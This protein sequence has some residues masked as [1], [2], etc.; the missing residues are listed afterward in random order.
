MSD[1]EL[2]S[3]GQDPGAPGTFD[4]SGADSGELVIITGGIADEDPDEGIEAVSDVATVD[5]PEEEQAAEFTL[6]ELVAE[7]AG[8]SALAAVVADEEVAPVAIPEHID[9]LAAAMSEA[10]AEAAPVEEEMWTRAPFW[11]LGAVWAVFAGVL[12]FLLWPKTSTGLES[13]PLYGLLVY[14]GT[15]LVIVG[16]IVGLVVWSRARARADFKDRSIVSRALML[17]AVGWTAAGVAVW[18]VAL[19]VLSLHHLDVF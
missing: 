19:V 15:G 5:E 13:S 7:M 9:P 10:F 4:E 17:R 3:D 16:L 12:S 1:V 2:P 18:V 14:G 11:V 8:V 6:D